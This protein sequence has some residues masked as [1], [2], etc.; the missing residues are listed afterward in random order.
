MRSARV[1]FAYPA[2]YAEEYLG[3]GRRSA[4]AEGNAEGRVGQKARPPSG[5]V[6]WKSRGSA[7]GPMERRSANFKQLAFVKEAM[8]DGEWY[9]LRDLERKC[10]F[11]YAQSSIS[12]R[13]REF[14]NFGL[15]IERRIRS[16]EGRKPLYE[17]R[18]VST[19]ERRSN[20]Q[21]APGRLGSPNAAKTKF[22]A[23]PHPRL[24]V[25]QCELFG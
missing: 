1:A 3:L 14:K 4:E 9:S 2:E 24:P 20:S 17:Y 6:E 13:L 15:V 11:A 7:G 23:Q 5:N 18:F 16:R 10:Q 22:G 25:M 21:T 8:S 12:A 19:D